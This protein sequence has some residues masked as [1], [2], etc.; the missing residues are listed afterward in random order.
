MLNSFYNKKSNTEGEVHADRKTYSI[1]KALSAMK[2]RPG[3]YFKQESY[4]EQLQA[5]LYGFAVGTNLYEEDTTIFWFIY[6]DE[7]DELIDKSYGYQDFKSLPDKEK[8]EIYM[9][10]IFKV[11]AQHY[12]ESARELGVL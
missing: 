2:H 6:Q 9:D 1:M 11:F 10:T 7:I 3:M 12:P 8:Y 5:F 4:Y